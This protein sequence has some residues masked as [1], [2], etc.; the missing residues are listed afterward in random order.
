MQT[1]PLMVQH[2]P[3]AVTAPPFI[4]IENVSKSF[5]SFKAVDSVSLSIR[6]GEIFALLGGSGCGK[7]TLLRMLAGFEA[8]TSGRIFIDG[9]DMTGI[10]PYER[11]V[12]MMFQSYALFPHM[13]V[14]RNIA[15]GLK[16]ENLTEAQ[17]KERVRE[18]LD[19]VQLTP[20]ALR[21]PHQISGGQRQRVALARAL[22]RH[23]KLLLLDEPLAALDKKL[24]EQTQFE[25]MN[26]QHK[27][28]VTFVVVTHDQEE[29]MILSD[30]IAVMDKG[31][32]K[33][34]GTPTEV[35]EYPNSRFVAGFI[36]SVTAFEGRVLSVDGAV[37]RVNIPALAT[38]ITARV[39]AGIEREMDVTVALR[40][41][42]IIISRERPD[43]PNAVSGVVDG[44]G[45]FGKDSLYKV[46]LPTG[47]TV[48]VNSVNARRVGENERVADW[49]D[50]VW[51]SFDP[52][53]VILL[54]T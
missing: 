22:A 5:G 47:T 28:G 37:A 3:A 12:N 38:Q 6:K 25:L 10:P 27:T 43:S 30:R 13:N 21:K 23:P 24:R 4:R 1:M 53:S 19:L 41:E 50:A 54:T 40:P 48:S 15:Y 39:A 52:T 46:K 44:L 35:Y 33:Q 20:Y 32:V 31:Q 17:R 29:A 18:M 34:I 51:L 36:G 42:K 49:E 14:E 7:T 26:I 16:H 11:P 9:Q 8:P 2:E 45:Y